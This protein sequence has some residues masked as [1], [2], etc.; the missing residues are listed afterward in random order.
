MDIQHIAKLA[1]LLIDADQEKLFTLQLT[2]ILAFVS[3]LQ[4]VSTENVEPTAQVTGLVNVY[5]ADVVDQS[6]ILTQAQVLSNA[7]KTHNG[8]FVVPS[9]W[10]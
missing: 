8:Y 2:A 3:K 1:N 5:R 10:T 6:R 9:V 4:S 7:K